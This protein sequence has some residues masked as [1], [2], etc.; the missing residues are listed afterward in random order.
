MDVLAKSTTPWSDKDRLIHFLR[1]FFHHPLQSLDL[2]SNK[3]QIY[4]SSTSVP[5][6]STSQHQ[7]TA[8]FLIETGRNLHRYDILNI[9]R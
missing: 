1:L 5:G 9:Q 8:S 7:L 6:D 4:I 3:K 2:Q